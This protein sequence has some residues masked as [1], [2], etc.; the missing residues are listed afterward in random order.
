[1]MSTMERAFEEGLRRRGERQ[2]GD[3][4]LIELYAV[5]AAESG[6]RPEELDAEERQRLAELALPVAFPN[7][8][9]VPESGRTEEPIEVVEYDAAWQAAF[10]EWRD[11]LVTALG[12]VAVRIEHMG[13]T[14]VPG[15]PAKPVIDIQVSIADPDDEASYVPQIEALGVQLR[16]RDRWHRYFRPFPGR[17]RDVQIHV[18][19]AGTE[20]ERDHLQFRD[21]LRAHPD[22]R[23]AYAAAKRRAALDWR[24]D[25]LAYTDAKTAVIHEIMAA[26]ARWGLDDA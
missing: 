2:R 3:V 18:C 4:G 12:P 10:A 5:F 19:A 24:D 16:S 20:W 13:S 1:M 26:A 23:A 7:F 8:E 11:R 17:P 25:R 15:L 14:A 6:R 22:A 9:V 21:H